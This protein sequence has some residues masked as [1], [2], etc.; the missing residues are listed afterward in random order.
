MIY[1]FLRDFVSE[2][3]IFTFTFSVPLQEQRSKT[4]SPANI[5][6]KNFSALSSL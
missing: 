2:V 1:Q 6:Q 3:I 4:L 5:A